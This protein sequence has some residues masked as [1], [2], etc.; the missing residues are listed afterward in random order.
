LELV[1]WFDLL[2]KDFCYHLTAISPGPILYI[3][4]EILAVVQKSSRN[5]SNNNPAPDCRGGHPK[6]G[7]ILAGN[8]YMYDE[9]ANVHRIVL[10]QDKSE[11]EG[12]IYMYPDLYVLPAENGISRMLF[13]ELEQL[14]N[15]NKQ[16][17][18]K[19]RKTSDS[20]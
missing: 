18:S 2:N 17:K 15:E 4:E 12:I 6:Y 7:S 16:L 8:W 11:H 5:N 20:A 19:D 1:G 9:W 10:E 14:I 3:A 13:Q